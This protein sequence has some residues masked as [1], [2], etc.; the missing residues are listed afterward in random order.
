MFVQSGT[1][2]LADVFESFQNMCLEIY[3]F[4]PAKFLTAPGLAWQTAFKKTKVKLDLLI[5]IDMLLMIE[6]CIRGGICHSVHRYAKANNKYMK[7]YDKNKEWSYLQYWDI[8]HS[9]GWAM[10][11]KPPINNFEWIKEISQF[12]WDFIKNYNEESNGGYFL[13]VDVQY[14]EKLHELHNDLPFLPERMKIEK[15]TKLVADLHNNTEYVKQIR[16]LKQALNN[17]FVLKKVHRVIKFNQN[18]WLKPYIDMNT[19]LTK[20]AKNE[21]EKDFSKLMTNAVFGKTMENVR[22]HRDIKLV[23]TERRRNYLV[24]E[25]NYHTTKFFTEHLL[26]IEMK[27]PRYLWINLSI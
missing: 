27:K 6:K 15:V 5:Y 12:N 10:L 19:D 21:F 11:Q 24:S 20:K 22:K 17:G 8:N 7:Y 16:N 14:L 9:F 25:P 2:F 13:E 4:D 1:L 26:V 18:A 3:E 23:T